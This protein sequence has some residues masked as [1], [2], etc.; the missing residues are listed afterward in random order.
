MNYY[1]PGTVYPPPAGVVYPPG[2]V[3]P[4]QPGV[5]YPPGTVIPPQPGVVYPPGYVQPVYQP[6][7]VQPV[8]GV[9]PPPM[10][11]DPYRYQAGMA[12]AREI[13]KGLNDLF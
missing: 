11:Y 6:G 7:Y 12:F 9:A 1:P 13:N 5:V 2:T 3:V 4:P 10:Y 8:V